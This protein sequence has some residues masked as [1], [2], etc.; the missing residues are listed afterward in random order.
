MVVQCTSRQFIHCTN[1]S[2]SITSFTW[3]LYMYYNSKVAVTLDDIECSSFVHKCFV[4]FK[5]HRWSLESPAVW[6]TG[7]RP[8]PPLLD[9]AHVHRLAV[10]IDVQLQLTVVDC[11]CTRHILPFS[12]Q[13][14]LSINVCVFRVIP[15]TCTPC[16]LTKTPPGDATA[17]EHFHH[18]R[19]LVG[20][21]TETVDAA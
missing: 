16:F 14:H 21:E 12:L 6:G 20:Q 11:Q 17:D 7:A 10:S 1:W 15:W 8:P 2:L 19:L 9:L 13:I 18:V 5:F 3:L 4:R